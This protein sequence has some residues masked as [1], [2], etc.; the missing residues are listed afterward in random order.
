MVILTMLATMLQQP[1][2][3]VDRD[4][5]H[6]GEDVIVTITVQTR[7]D[8][9]VEVRDPA[10]TL[11]A[12]RDRRDQSKVSISG[13]EAFRTTTRTLTLR[14]LAEGQGVI[15]S[16]PV[17]QGDGEW[18]ST[19]ITIQIV[20]VS[21]SQGRALDRRV[22]SLL[23]SMEP[24]VPSPEEVTLTVSAVPERVTLGQ[25]VDIIVAAWVPRAIR[26]RL[27]NQP[28]LETPQV[29]GAWS[30]R[31][32]T[33]A[34]VALS[35]EVGGILYDL[36]VQHE[37]IFPLAEGRAEVGAAK[38]TYSLPLTYT[39]LS[40]EQRYEIESRP[41]PIEVHP[42][43]PPAPTVAFTGA[44]GS[45][46]Q[47]V[48]RT[49]STALAI[50]D[51]VRVQATVRGQG[52][53][54]LWPEPRVA[55]PAAVRAYPQ[56]TQVTLDDAPGDPLRGTKAFTYLVVADSAGI[57]R[58]DPTTYV[59]FDVAAGQYRELQAPAID[60]TVTG[61]TVPQPLEGRPP[62]L[63]PRKWLSAEEILR[64]ALPLWV[65]VVV[66]APLL[67]AGLGLLR[68]WRGR[69]PA[70]RGRPRSA[71]GPA[72]L[73]AAFRRAIESLIPHATER[74]GT[75]L[76]EAL[77]AAGVEASLAAHAARVRDRL[78]KAV[79]GPE[80][81][82]DSAELTLEVREVLKALAADEESRGRAVFVAVTVLTVSLSWAASAQTPEELYRAGA[83]RLA[84]EAFRGRVAAE[85][86][87]AAHWYNLG[88]ALAGMGEP[89]YARAAW[90]HA[91]RLAPRHTVVRRAERLS[92]GAAVSSRAEVWIAPV[93]GAEALL[94]A[95]ALWTVGWVLVVFR[96]RPT[97]LAGGLSLILAIGIAAYAVGV[98]RHYARPAG[99]VLKP[100]T[101]LR[102][103]PYGPA[104][105]TERL[106]AAT[107]VT[108][109][110]REAAW[111]LVRVGQRRGWLLASEVVRL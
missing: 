72:G 46:L 98:Q 63:A 79:Y 86:Y 89:V 105:S 109:E 108:I 19:P 37:V 91:A 26:A 102:V 55:W 61:A 3:A 8:V 29:R 13:E 78:R 73:E 45:D 50:G 65:G 58:L 84:A 82:T 66:G 87:V 44:I 5:V 75:E 54:A 76:A 77:R 40:R 20:G 101:Q 7:S 67:F 24:A 96:R 52:N 43:P 97:R 4:R 68:R 92:R 47:L 11:L 49:T 60:F 95:I 35:R 53:V 64:T 83:S 27:R 9:P 71:D 25:Q 34:G 80:G 99:L 56:E 21:P 93:T 106:E 16:V 111:L 17:R 85:P 57:H 32:A 2:V 33:P 38:V 69:V 48:V 59:Y 15:G 14:A 88:Q 103:A 104:P 6:V 42:H 51:A 74:S 18:S 62:L 94:T 12:I 1:Q 31:R 81:E 28:T 36:Y 22:E 100:E 90:I 23:R 39:F 110:R 41:I 30:Y 70:K 10:L 107:P